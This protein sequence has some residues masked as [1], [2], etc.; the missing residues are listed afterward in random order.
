MVLLK[1]FLK[2]DIFFIY[3]LQT[4][5]NRKYFLNNDLFSFQSHLNWLKIE[6]KL[7]YIIYYKKKVRV[8]YVKVEFINDKK[9]DISIIIKKKYRKRNLASA[10]IKKIE[11]KFINK[12]IRAVIHKKNKASLNLFKKYL[13]IKKKTIK[14]FIFFEKLIKF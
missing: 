2:K 13:Y 7:I 4:T 5:K 9:I 6:N 8:G 10:V 3:S 11:K 1:K 14:N 12:I